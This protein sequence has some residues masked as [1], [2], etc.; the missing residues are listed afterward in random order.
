MNPYFKGKGGGGSV[1]FK[2]QQSETGETL[3]SISKLKYASWPERGISDNTF[4]WAG[5]RMSYSEKDGITP[6]A[7]YFPYHDKDGK[8]CGYKKRD[9]TKPKEERGHFTT[10]GYVGTSCQ[11]FLQHRAKTNA[12][13][14]IICEGELD[15]LAMWE[16]VCQY[17]N[18]TGKPELKKIPRAIVSISCGTSNAAANIAYNEKWVKKWLKGESGDKKLIISFDNDEANSIEREKGII[19]GREATEAVAHYLQSPDL[20]TMPYPSHEETLKDA[21]DVLLK[22]G[23]GILNEMVCFGGEPIVSSQVLRASQ[24]SFEDIMRPKPPCL[25]INSLPKLTQMKATPRKGEVTMVTAL[26]GAGKSTIVSE[27]AW[28]MVNQGFKVGMLFLEEDPEETFR[29]MIAKK[30]GISFN[31]F[32]EDPSKCGIPQENIR[33]AYEWVLENDLL[34]FHKDFGAISSLS[35]LLNEIR[36]MVYIHNVDYIIFD[37]IS[38]A[39]SG[40]ET[41]D[42]RKVID[43]LM[44]EVAAFIKK[45][46]NDVGLVIV[47]HLNRKGG[48]Q[49]KAPRRKPDEPETPFWVQVYKED[50]RGSS[51]LEGVSYTILGIEQEILPSRKRG[52]VRLVVLKNRTGAV[53]GEADYLTLDKETGKLVEAYG[54]SEF[55]GF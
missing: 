27:M 42:E 51:S 10:I 28:D 31:L 33:A 35:A 3:Q 52:R 13:R 40:I 54:G 4:K 15:A 6:V 9:L 50:L 41:M 25:N 12:K 19:K 24:I 47:S 32:N 43:K 29:R 44:A 1:S 26:S 48:D 2:Y 55:E 22:C 18:A 45:P 34:C 30:L 53:L 21:N 11:F 20:M 5:V 8:I 36:T 49:I 37:H 23:F 17:A 14:L 39:V 46:Q 38:I 16:A 7:I